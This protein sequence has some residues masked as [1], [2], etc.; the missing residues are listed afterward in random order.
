MIQ[1]TI[2]E[3]FKIC[4]DPY[5]MIHLLASSEARDYSIYFDVPSYHLN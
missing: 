2:A 4:E 3:E 5:D 1:I